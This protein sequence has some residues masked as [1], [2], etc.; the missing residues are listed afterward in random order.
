LGHNPKK[1]FVD[2]I[3]P[4]V[5]ASESTFSDSQSA[6]IAEEMSILLDIPQNAD[7]WT[8]INMRSVYMKGK[9][10]GTV[11]KSTKK[12]V[13][14]SKVWKADMAR[15]KGQGHR[16]GTE[17]AGEAEEGEVEAVGEAEIG[18]DQGGWIEGDI[19]KR[20]RSRI[21]REEE[22]DQ[23]DWEGEEEEGYE[24]LQ[25]S[26]ITVIYGHAGESINSRY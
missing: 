7:P 19:A 13:P 4:L 22:E 3:Q 20:R 11:T 12:G 21:R 18:D 26:P 25:C 6:R 23:D 17:E 8:L 15:C 24:D 10:K 16:L 2:T 9:K 14:W 5:T 1:S